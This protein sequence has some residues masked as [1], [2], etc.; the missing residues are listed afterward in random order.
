MT[1]QTTA[2]RHS[3][4][5]QAL[6][7]IGAASLISLVSMAASAQSSE[8]GNSAD[9][10]VAPSGQAR[11]DQTATAQLQNIYVEGQYPGADAPTDGYTAQTSRGATKTDTP[12]LETPQT[13]DVVT[14]EQIADQGSRNINDALRYT[15]GAFTGLAGASRRQDVVSLRGFHAGDV[16]NMFLDGMRLMSD[17]GSY[18]NIQ[19]DPFFLE[20]IDII[21]GP[22][23]VLYG[24]AMPGGLVNYTTKKPLS[25][26]QGEIQFYGGSFDT[27]GGGVDLTGPL[28]N[29][30]WG[31]YRVIGKA[32]TS[33]TQFDV[34]KRESY[35]IMP[36]LSLDLSEDTH[37]LLQAYIQHDP[38][39]GFHGAVPY[40]LAADNSR[41]GRTV[42]SSWVDASRGNAH[43]D[44]DER[45]FSYELT[46]Q[47]NDHITLH[48]RS[49][50]SDVETELAQI[51]QTGFTA[52]ADDGAT[53]GRYYSGA[54]EHLK[55]FSTDNYAQFDFATGPV[56]HKLLTGLS[57]QQR[58]NT[59][60]NSSALGSNL[61]PFNPDYSGTGLPAGTEPALYAHTD[62]KLKQFGA[63]IQ[64][65][66]SWK[67]WHVVLSGREDYLKRD[68]LSQLSGARDTRRD[69]SFS[70]RAAILYR[71]KWGVSPYFSYSE[72]FNP[73]TDSSVDG[74]VPEPVDS[75]QYEIGVKYQ[76]NGVNALF[77]LALYDLTQKN[78]Q[79]RTSVTPVRYTGVGD[80]ESK[81]VEFTAKA[82]VTDK[83]HVTAGYAYNDVE[84][85]DSFTDTSGY[86]VSAGNT[87]VLSPEQM[88]SLWVKYD[89]PKG[90]S[91][92]LGG[93]Y[94]GKSYANSSN[95]LELSD[96]ALMDAYV[97]FDLGQMMP[98]LK[99]VSVRVNANNLLDKKYVEGCFS[100][101]YCYFGEERQV[102][103]TLDYRF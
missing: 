20:R 86:S 3:S 79:Q 42:D 78:V 62:R 21:K 36:E 74:V 72:A 67:R 15:P 4:C 40:D 76:P 35:T 6:S 38:A 44:R 69:D 51:Y 98:K 18:S 65:Q 100:E 9:A 60:R 96:Y 31:S 63:Y 11:Q 84:Y 41:F 90:V 88:A 2:S 97:G 64:D 19:I 70:G 59:I 54:D 93:R 28:P 39:G 34:V 43:F 32:S 24:R 75:D 99:G 83:L 49:R 7:L 58:D 77:T 94:I 29:K 57:Y 10:A 53:L 17:G 48:S 73:S 33:D 16:N 13:V 68:Y 30:D 37:L 5:G 8:A 91:A 56:Q 47:V 95:T 12:L 22:S 46:H 55:A 103:A 87:P 61:D 82:D 85:Q 101:N 89:F 81:G 23:S 80:V 45:L 92:G 71:S 14:R 25:K 102:T 50:Y 27:F 66:L 1:E 52:A 26:Q